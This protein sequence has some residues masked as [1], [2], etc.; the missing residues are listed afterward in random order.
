VIVLVYVALAVAYVKLPKNEWTTLGFRIVNLVTLIAA[1]VVFL[2]SPIADYLKNRGLAIRK[3]LADAAAMRSTA[4]TQL[5]S[6]RSKL[7]GLPAE[8]DLLRRRG[9]EEVTN[10]RQRMKD[11]AAEERQHLLERARRDIDIQLR[12]ARRALLEHSAALAVSLTRDRVQREITP[13][14]QA[15]LIDRYASGVRS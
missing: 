1:L 3:D 7:A 8:L 12:I 10:E 5:S 13:D 2:R 4:E 11:A 9:E 15:R 6:V 14:D